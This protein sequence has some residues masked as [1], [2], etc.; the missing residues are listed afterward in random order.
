MLI[1]NENLFLW[2]LL[3]LV[4][5]W[6]KIG[7]RTSVY[8]SF[9]MEGFHLSVS[10]HPKSCCLQQGLHTTQNLVISLAQSQFLNRYS[11]ECYLIFLCWEGLF[12]I[13]KHIKEMSGLQKYFEID[14]L[15]IM[16]R[17]STVWLKLFHGHLLPLF[18]VA[19]VFISY[20][21]GCIMWHILSSSSKI[22][23]SEIQTDYFS[24]CF[25]IFTLK[26]GK[27][28][29][30]VV[31]AFSWCSPIRSFVGFGECRRWRSSNILLLEIK[32]L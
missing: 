18:L 19:V 14:K 8:C 2:N 29:L 15:L 31:V 13:P 9:E 32:G 6:R 27:C 4:F 26:N 11:L 1:T 17:K 10:L 25:L 28:V 22:T 30:K 24:F 7:K 16:E 12:V 20:C 3:N 23:N 5:E 21:V